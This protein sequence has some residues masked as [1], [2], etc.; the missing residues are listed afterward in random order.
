MQICV[1][2]IVFKKYDNSC[3]WVTSLSSPLSPLLSAPVW[4][5]KSDQHWTPLNTTEHHSKTI[6]SNWKVESRLTISPPATPPTP[7]WASFL[8][9]SIFLAEVNPVNPINQPHILI[10]TRIKGPLIDSTQFSLVIRSDIRVC[11]ITTCWHWLHTSL[12]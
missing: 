3:L 11:L 9:L 5:L 6:R 4:C 10:L 12:A 2:K 7:D 8:T 1:K